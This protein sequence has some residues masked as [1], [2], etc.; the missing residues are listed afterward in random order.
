[1]PRAKRTKQDFRR[2]T[3]RDVAAAAG[4]SLVTVSRVI[5]NHPSVKESSRQRV[6]EAMR[7]LNY[8]PD[9]AAQSLRR[10]SSRIIGFLMPD[11]TNGVNAIIAQQVERE[12]RQAG[13][14][15]MLACSNFDSEIEMEALRK[16]RSNRVDGIVLQIANEQHAGTLQVL[17]GVDCPLVLV[18]RDIDV[19]ADAVLSNHYDATR[20][21]IRY[22]LGLGHRDIAFITAAQSMRPGRERLRAFRDEM[23]AHGVTPGQRRIFPDAQSIEYGYRAACQMFSETRPSAIVAAG[24]QILYGVLQA[25]REHNL[26]IPEDIS[27]IGADHRML[28]TVMEPKITM[29]DRELTALGTEAATLLL[30]RIEGRFE[31]PPRRLLLPLSVVLNGSC[32]PMDEKR[33][34]EPIARI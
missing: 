25:V 19:P 13:Y 8:H 30:D 10:N 3:I 28:A 14:T 9:A 1:M 12:M 21:A 32:R 23:A 20:E 16:F 6:H 2:P 18:D 17:R 33:K 4:I 26:R 29:I 5:N 27:I 15:V 24:N 22:L 7:E 31:G 11:F 34:A